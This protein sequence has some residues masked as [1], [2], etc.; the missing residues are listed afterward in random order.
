M[1]SHSTWRAALAARLA[2][3]KTVL[4]LIGG[5]LVLL[6]AVPA[7]RLKLDESIESFYTPD[8]PFLLA[9]QES[10]RTFGGDEFVMVAYQADDPTSQDELLKIREFSDELSAVPGVRPESTQ[11]LDDILNNPRAS[12]QMRIYLRIIN[13][14]LLE[15]SRRVLIGDDGQTTAIVL[16]LQ[17]E[18]ESPVSRTETFRRIRQLADAHDPPAFVAGEPI[19]VHDM[20]RYV[21]DDGWLLG[22]A[23]SG[24]LMF[25]ILLFF[26]NLRWVFLPIAVIHVTLIWTKGALFLSGMQ[27]SMVSSM[28]TSLITIIGIATVMHVTV[29]YRELRETLTRTEAWAGTVERLVGPI[30]WTC[31]TT[32][33]GFASLLSSGITPVRSFGIMMSLGTLLVPLACLLILPAGVLLGNW[34]ADPRHPWGEDW[35]RRRLRGLA[36]SAV[37]WK[38]AVLTCAL[39]LSSVAGWGLSRLTVETDF[40][41]NF[42]EESPIVQS[43]RFFED[44]LGGVGSWEIAFDAPE[45]LSPDYLDRIRNLVDELRQ[46]QLPDGTKLTK[47][48]ALTDGLDPIPGLLARRIEDKLTYVDQ[49]QPE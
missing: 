13:R 34:Q 46:L 17:D 30:F 42:L 22:L 36:V 3:W 25:V 15:L 8:D 26:R 19:Q 24:L 43:L 27:L 14:K 18:A 48:V 31:L 6:L 32:A 29:T 5:L 21:E 9:Y 45:E 49:L 47:V 39:A 23:S 37:R 35:A 20:F 12:L 38:W 2:E 40:S 7:S 1:S 44:R 28:L 16:R 4:L 33:I 10:K 11:D 41:K